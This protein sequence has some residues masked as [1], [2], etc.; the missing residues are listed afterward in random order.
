M[1]TDIVDL[2]KW[3]K[4]KAD[5]TTDCKNLTN[6]ISFWYA[7]IWYARFSTGGGIVENKCSLY[8]Y[9][10]GREIYLGD[11]PSVR[12][13]R[14]FVQGLPIIPKDYFITIS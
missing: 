9:S 5:V 7:G 12:R 11:F 3:L 13:A 6:S 1:R 14:E 4:V 2:A 8:V 10:K